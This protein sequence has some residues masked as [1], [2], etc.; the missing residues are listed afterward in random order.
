MYENETYYFSLEED[1]QKIVHVSRLGLETV[2]FSVQV[3]DHSSAILSDHA[4]EL[5][6]SK[7]N[8]IRANHRYVVANVRRSLL[9]WSGNRNIYF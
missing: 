2:R 3:C 5:P 1:Y 6:A 4:T 9:L 7:I 8:F